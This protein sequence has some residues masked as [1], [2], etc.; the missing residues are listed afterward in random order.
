MDV[1]PAIAGVSLEMSDSQ[2]AVGRGVRQA[3]ME[4][5]RASVRE[6]IGKAPLFKVERLARNGDWAFLQATMEGPDG[7]AFDYA[8][9]PLADAAAQG[10]VSRVFAALLRRDASGWHIMAQAVGPTDLAWEDWPRRFG[11]PASLFV[12]R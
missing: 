5:A 11:A 7:A 10:V 8:G 2:R 3:I 1:V 4:A 9:T 12:L 6:R